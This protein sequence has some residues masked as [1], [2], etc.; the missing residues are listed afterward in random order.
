LVIIFR[1]KDVIILKWSSR[2]GEF[3][4]MPLIPDLPIANKKETTEKASIDFEKNMEVS[5]LLY[6]MIVN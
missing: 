1:L 4:P 5:L 6:N 3:H 2:Q